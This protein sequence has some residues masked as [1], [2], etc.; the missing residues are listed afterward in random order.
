MS[1]IKVKLLS[2]VGLGASIGVK[3][4]Q[5]DLPANIAKD[6]I[7][8]KRA[9]RVGAPEPVKAVSLDAGKKQDGK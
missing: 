7:N 2:N 3:G 9:E 1:T 6:L 5:H 8:R 4:T